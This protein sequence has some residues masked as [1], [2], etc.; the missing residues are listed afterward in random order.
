LESQYRFTLY[1][2]HGGQNVLS[3]SCFKTFHPRGIYYKRIMSGH[4]IIAVLALVCATIFNIWSGLITSEIV[5]KVNERLPPDQQFSHLWWYWAKYRRLDAAYGAYYPEGQL[6]RR[7]RRLFYV[8]CF[9]MIIC[10]WAIFSSQW[11][12]LAATCPL[13]TH[14]SCRI[15]NSA[16]VAAH[17]AI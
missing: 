15:L 2:T 5:D 1:W 13:T 10:A 8:T 14:P 4:W 6:R 16:A 3:A 9:F 17:V 12:E 7:S 11:R